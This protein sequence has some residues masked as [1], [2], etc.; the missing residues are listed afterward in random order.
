MAFIYV[1]KNTKNNKLYVGRTNRS[2]KIRLSEHISSSKKGG[3]TYLNKAMRKYGYQN[4][5]LEILEECD[6]SEVSE[7]EMYWIEHLS[8]K[9]PNGYNLTDGGEGTIGMV[10]SD[11]Y[12][13]KLSLAHQGKKLS[14]E[15]R[16]KLSLVQTG[17]K[18]SPETCKKIGDIHRGKKL[19]KEQKQKLREINTGKN[20]SEESKRK[21][22][23]ALRGRKLSPEHI[24]KLKGR[25]ISAET[26]EKISRQNYERLSDPAYR[27]KLKESQSH[28]CKPIY[29]ESVDG[30]IK[31]TIRSL[32]DCSKWLIENGYS[33]NKA[34]RSVSSNIKKAIRNDSV[35]YGFKFNFAKRI[36]EDDLI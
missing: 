32:D 23:D 35:M 21:I 26:R 24:Q 34:I 11:E 16:Q 25:V 22:G 30:T 33:K 7:R 6:E 14:K 15:H 36:H 5:K 3:K 13:K 8:T 17:K 12:K 27:Q 28:R 20:H 19:T 29:M 9:V 2:I 4:F 18:R 1:I 10:F 31:Q